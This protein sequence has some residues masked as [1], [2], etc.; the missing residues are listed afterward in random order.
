MAATVSSLKIRLQARTAFATPFQGDTLFGQLCWGLRHGWGEA[1]LR[2]LLTG[3]TAGQPFLVV[4]DA[5]PAGYLPLPALPSRYWAGE[6]ADPSRRKEL[7]RQIWLPE[8]ALSL[9]M[10]G[11]QALAR[12]AKD[13][14]AATASRPQHRNSLDRLTQTTGKGDGFSPYSVRQWWYP[15]GSALEIHLRLDETRLSRGELEAAL[16]AMGETG[17]GKDANVGLGKFTLEGPPVE[18]AMM[19][20]GAADAWLTLAPCAPQ[21]LGFDAR[22]SYYRPFTR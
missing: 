14:A 1:R 13:I 2:E 18:A 8:F 22:R 9:P 12:Q 4:S 5:F 10:A 17:Y 21:G 7:K 19:S 16:K 11:W 6:A 3:Y 15:E 20:P